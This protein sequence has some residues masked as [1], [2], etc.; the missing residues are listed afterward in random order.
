MTKERIVVDQKA[1]TR[2][3][4]CIRVCPHNS[5]SLVE[6]RICFDDSACFSC[7]HCRAVCPADAI[8]IGAVPEALELVS[9]ADA[10]GSW[11]QGEMAIQELVALMRMRRSCRNYLDRDVPDAVL[12]DLVKIGTTAPSGTNS[13]GWGFIIT[14][15]RKEVEFLGALVGEFYRRLNK[16]AKNPLL[17]L[18]AKIFAGDALGRYRR[19]YCQQVSEALTA[20]ETH[21]E[22]RLFH[23]APAVLL[24]TGKN[25]ASC[26]GEDALLATQNILLAAHGMGLGSCLIGFAVEAIRRDRG[27]QRALGMVDDEKLYAAIALGYPA[28][29]FLRPANRRRVLPRRTRFFRK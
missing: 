8:G 20:W 11:W 22:D 9:V 12:T 16:K 10:A 19:N 26:P 2:C 4:E 7:G 5:L 3:R 14:S 17:Y 25:S 6:N 21:R 29:K 27:L 24:I 18:A 23:G 13:Q 28:V 15:G 1:C